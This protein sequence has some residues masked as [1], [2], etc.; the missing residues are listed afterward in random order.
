MLTLD[1]DVRYLLPVTVALQLQVRTSVDEQR[2]IG[3]VFR[4]FSDRFGATR[5][6]YRP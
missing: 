6:Y 4:G 2:R 3:T 5:K 1:V